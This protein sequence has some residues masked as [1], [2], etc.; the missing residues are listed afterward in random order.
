MR[1]FILTVLAAVAAFAQEHAGEH[2]WSRRN[3]RRRPTR[4]F[5]ARRPISRRSGTRLPEDRAEGRRS[6]SPI[7]VQ[8]REIRTFPA[9]LTWIWCWRTIRISRSSDCRWSSLGTR[10][11]E[12]IP[13]SIRWWSPLLHNDAPRDTRQRRSR[14]RERRESAHPAIHVQLAADAADR[15][16]VQRR[17]Q[18]HQSIHEQR[19]LI[20]QSGVSTRLQREHHAAAA[21]KPRIL[22]HQASDHHRAQPA[23]CR[24]SM[25]FRTRF[26]DWWQTRR[27]PTGMWSPLAKICV[28]RNRHWLCS[29]NR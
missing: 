4:R 19:A 10:S 8:R 1:V 24:A 17:L 13:S 26:S 20:F 3:T 27:T 6:G 18:H 5:S 29:I 25:R 22:L 11:C 28:C 7:I 23:A 21:A 2:D 12:A 9:R 15:Y 14:G 16:D